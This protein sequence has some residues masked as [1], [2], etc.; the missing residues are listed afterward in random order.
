MKNKQKQNFMVD[1]YPPLMELQSLVCCMVD[2]E[3]RGRTVM[4]LRESDCG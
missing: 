1:F 2:N 4:V 3:E